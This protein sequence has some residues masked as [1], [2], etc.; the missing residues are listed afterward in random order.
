MANIALTPLTADDREQ[1]ILDNQR[2]FKYGALEE[3]G[4]RDDH[5]EEDGEIISRRTIENSI[6]GGVAYRIREDGRIVGGL[7]LKIDEK[8]QHTFSFITTNASRQ[9]QN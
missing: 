7:V 5:F 3:F 9:K 2:A 1:F 4:R 6:D 8:T